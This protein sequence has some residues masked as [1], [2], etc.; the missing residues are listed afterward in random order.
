MKQKE[1]R[2]DGARIQSLEFD[3]ESVVLTQNNMRDEHGQMWENLD[4]C[5]LELLPLTSFLPT[6]PRTFKGG[7]HM[8]YLYFWVF[9]HQNPS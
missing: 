2:E 4:F 1:V 6:L 8:H 7:A 3:R 5:F 9:P